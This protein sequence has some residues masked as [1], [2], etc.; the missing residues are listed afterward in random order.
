M[1]NGKGP[2][3]VI[4][5]AG[6]GSRYGGYKQLDAFGP[7]NETIMDLSI[8]DAIDAGF[9]KI[10]LVINRDIENQIRENVVPKYQDSVEIDCAFQDLDSLPPGFKRPAD[11]VKPWGTAHAVLAAEKLVT[12]PFAVINADD[13]YGSSAFVQM[14]NELGTMALDSDEFCMIGYHLANTLSRHGGVSR[15]ICKTRNGYLSSISETKNVREEGEKIVGEV[16]GKTISLSVDD[17]VSMNFWG[18]SPL[19]FAVLNEKLVSFLQNRGHDPSAEFFITDTL[20]DLMAENRVSVRVL[21]T[22]EKWFGVTHIQDSDE[23]RNGIQVYLNS[24]KQGT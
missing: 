15:G 23:V 7:A 18:F 2:C 17:T 20:D 13:F 4:L 19:V 5:A 3:L 14:K 22:N 24:K 11:R 6:L 12:I 1:N 16:G 8:I 10:I 21:K 9:K